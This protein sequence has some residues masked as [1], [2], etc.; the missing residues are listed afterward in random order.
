MGNWVSQPKRSGDIFSDVRHELVAI[1]KSKSQSDIAIQLKLKK[2]ASKSKFL[3][4]A[5]DDSNSRDSSRD[6][7]FK[8]SVSSSASASSVP[9]AIAAALERTKK[10]KV[11]DG[12][13]NADMGPSD[14]DKDKS[15]DSKPQKNLKQ[16]TVTSSDV[17]MQGKNEDALET[18]VTGN[19]SN[20]NNE[21]NNLVVFRPKVPNPYAD[22]PMK[23]DQVFGA[24]RTSEPQPTVLPESIE[25]EWGVF[26]ETGD[27]SVAGLSENI[28][29]KPKQ[30]TTRQIEEKAR[31]QA[32]E[33]KTKN[34]KAFVMPDKPAKFQKPKNKKQEEEEPEVSK[35]KEETPEKKAA[36]IPDPEPVEKPSSPIPVAAFIAEPPVYNP[37]EPPVDTL[38]NLEP[39]LSPQ[40][41]VPVEPRPE[42]PPEETKAIEQNGFAGHRRSSPS[43]G[44]VLPP[45][46]GINGF[47][48]TGRLVLRAAI[49]SGL[50]VKAI[51]DPF[52]PVNYMEK[53]LH[54]TTYFMIK[55]LTCFSFP[56]ALFAHIFEHLIG[57]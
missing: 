5:K 11:N 47:E 44:K 16:E 28:K 15:T 13:N 10:E 29:L 57:Q 2:S 39:E 9:K 25:R 4:H 43:P 19:E 6:R 33:R 51:N 48:R 3:Q 55:S 20:E 31:I 1:K 46:I 52:I 34:G 38:I 45:K 49:E 50:D 37:T 7:G 17:V 8:K 40:L 30:L 53:H 42:P 32:E 24:L 36:S 27:Y 23:L 54:S 22:A 18:T 14:A 56:L 21:E 26:Y 12:S 35:V 41:E